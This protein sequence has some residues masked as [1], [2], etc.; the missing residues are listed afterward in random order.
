M[1]NKVT[2]VQVAVIRYA[3]TNDGDVNESICKE[4]ARLVSKHIKQH[5]MQC[6]RAKFWAS[7]RI[8]VHIMQLPC[9]WGIQTSQWPYGHVW[10]LTH[11]GRF[12]LPKTDHTKGGSLPSI[13]EHLDTCACHLDKGIRLLSDKSQFCFTT[14]EHRVHV[15]WHQGE[16]PNPANVVERHTGD[17]PV[18]IRVWLQVVTMMA[19]GNMKN[20]E[21][22]WELLHV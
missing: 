14:D 4:L 15:W 17:T 2:N 5:W 12:L 16:R 7:M 11:V 10:A 13:K 21:W 18:I 20:M 6:D 3:Q 8:C 22:K 9:M 19:H 1:T